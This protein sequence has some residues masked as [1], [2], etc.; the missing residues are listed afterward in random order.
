MSL[1]ASLCLATLGW[2]GF[3][4]FHRQ[5]A[6]PRYGAVPI[7]ERIDEHDRPLSD[8]TLRGAVWVADFFFLSCP[9]SCPKLTAKMAALQETL[10]SEAQ[11]APTKRPIRLVSFSVDPENDTPPKL[12]E[13]AKKHGARDGV[14]SFLT[15]PADTLESIVVSGF[16]LQ[17][18]RQGAKPGEPPSAYTIMHGDWFVLVDAEG[19]LRGY[20]D[21]TDEERAQALVRDARRLAGAR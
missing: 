16:K 7:F 15:G 12:L 11:S 3:Q 5:P 17:L 10:A 19:T 1:A 8:R 6:L 14:W 21:M 9:T 20:Y 18:E 13:Y 4:R 2:A